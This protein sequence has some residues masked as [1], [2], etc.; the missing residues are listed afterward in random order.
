MDMAEPSTTHDN[1]AAGGRPMRPV[2]F[3]R[4]RANASMHMCC[5]YSPIHFFEQATTAKRGV[6]HHGRWGCC[7]LPPLLL[8]DRLYDMVSYVAGYKRSSSRD[9]ELR[10]AQAST[11]TFAFAGCWGWKGLELCVAF[12]MGQD[13]ALCRYFPRRFLLQLVYCR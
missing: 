5:I 7:L 13:F 12:L 10:V 2:T 9:E 8:Y 1:I 4:D 6:R 11:L 3:K